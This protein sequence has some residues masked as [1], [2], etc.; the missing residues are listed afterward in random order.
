[1]N[2]DELRSKLENLGYQTSDGWEHGCGCCKVDFQAK[3]ED[4]WWFYED[5]VL[6]DNYGEPVDVEKLLNGKI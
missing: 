3:V 4:E 1:M 5:E 2:G 6:W